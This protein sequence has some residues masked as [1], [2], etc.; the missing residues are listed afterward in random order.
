M[1]I[2]LKNLNIVII[3]AGIVLIALG[4]ILMSTENFID[5]SKFSLSLYVSPPLIM[6]GHGI[7]AWGIIAGTR[8]GPI[9]AGDNKFEKATQE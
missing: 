3:L 1:Q 8:R 6:I 9:I 2:P 4:Y 5:A 7:V